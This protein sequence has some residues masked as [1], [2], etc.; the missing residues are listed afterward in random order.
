MFILP[1]Y[2]ADKIPPGIEITLT[3]PAIA[4]GFGI[5]ILIAIPVCRPAVIGNS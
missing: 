4:Q 1:H 3:W 5:G 2:L